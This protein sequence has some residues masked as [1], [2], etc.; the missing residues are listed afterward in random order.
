MVTLL[1]D[2]R[3]IYEQ[4]VNVEP[5]LHKEKLQEVVSQLKDNEKRIHTLKGQD[6]INNHLLAVLERVNKRK[7]FYVQTILSDLLRQRIKI[8][9]DSLAICPSITNSLTLYKNISLTTLLS[10]IQEHGSFDSIIHPCLTQLKT[11]CETVLFSDV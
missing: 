7:L 4:L 3:T 8:E 5:L 6:G 11:L 10:L 9:S 2:Y 1:S